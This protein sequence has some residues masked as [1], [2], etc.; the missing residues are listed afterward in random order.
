MSE[1]ADENC[2]LI[3]PTWPNCHWC[4]ESTATTKYEKS[5]TF[6]AVTLLHK[7]IV[8]HTGLKIVYSWVLTY[9]SACMID[10]VK[11]SSPTSTR[12]FKISRSCIIGIL[13]RLNKNAWSFLWHSWFSTH[14]C[15]YMM[16]VT[17][18]VLK[19]TESNFLKIPSSEKTEFYV[20]DDWNSYQ[21]WF[22]ITQTCKCTT[23]TYQTE[24]NKIFII[25]RPVCN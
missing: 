13:F 18:I 4:P 23:V 8:R 20:I 12:L 14:S 5:A 2:V 21:L 16:S 25:F 19:I 10:R 15:T 11:H 9:T 24:F 3:L 17:Y 22:W 1:E 7:N 6:G